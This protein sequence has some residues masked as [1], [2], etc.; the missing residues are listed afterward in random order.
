MEKARINP[1]LWHLNCE[2]KSRLNILV[3]KTL[4]KK[5]GEGLTPDPRHHPLHRLSGLTA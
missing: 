1:G 2:W 3:S 5:Q 4:H